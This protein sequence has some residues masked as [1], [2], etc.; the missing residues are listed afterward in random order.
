MFSHFSKLI[1]TENMRVRV[2]LIG[3]M[4]VVYVLQ[5]TSEVINVN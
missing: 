3:I 5:S 2:N 4:G 1:W